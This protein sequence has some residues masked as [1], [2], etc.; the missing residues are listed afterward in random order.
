MLFREGVIA[1]F[2]GETKEDKEKRTVNKYCEY[3]K[4]ARKDG[5][6]RKCDKRI[7]VKDNGG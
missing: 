3:C 7:E 4:A 5:D 6:C 2:V 1:F